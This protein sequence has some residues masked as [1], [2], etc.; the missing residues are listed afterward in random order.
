MPVGQSIG[1]RS[2][3]SLCCVQCQVPP[4]SWNKTS[5][6][7]IV[8]WVRS[9]K[10]GM[11]QRRAEWFTRWTREVAQAGHINISTFEEGF[12]RVA[13]VAGAL[14]HERP[15]LAPLYK[16][17]SL[18]PRGSVR[19]V[20]A[21]VSFFL[22]H[23]S[24]QIEENRHHSC[25]T[26]QRSSVVSPRVD[27][28]A[29]E[30]RTGLN[31]WLLVLDQ[32]GTP[33]PWRSPW[34]SMEVTE[35]KWPWVYEKGGRPAM[36]ISTLEALAVLISL[37]LLFGGTANQHRSKIMVAPTWTDN[38]GNRSDLNK[39]MSTKFSTCAVLMELATYTK[40]MGLV[41]WTP[42]ATRWQTATAVFSTHAD[43]FTLRET[44]NGKYQ[45]VR[46]EWDVKQRQRQLLLEQRRGS[47]TEPASG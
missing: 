30:G 4:L 38:R 45:T 26:E 40:K 8:S 29:S 3:H 41:E 17:M 24:K 32:N 6:G 1:Q 5:G 28:Q 13:Y 11:S 42:R 25:A 10:L 14:E 9:H 23:L 12:G 16:F 19:K 20:P 34:F 39:V 15:F 33:D 43:V 2:W 35:K 22:A 44:F 27:A 46:C 47:K 36:I 31:G 37:R 7:D 18:R 21:Y